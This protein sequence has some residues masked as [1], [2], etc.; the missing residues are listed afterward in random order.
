MRINAK[1][2]QKRILIKHATTRENNTHKKDVIASMCEM[3]VSKRTEKSRGDTDRLLCAKPSTDYRHLELKNARQR[4]RA[5][6]DTNA[7]A[8]EETSMCVVAP[9]S[10]IQCSTKCKSTQT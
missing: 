6:N 2:H 10:E 4:H 5:E 8:V 1:T 7:K 9:M 3:V